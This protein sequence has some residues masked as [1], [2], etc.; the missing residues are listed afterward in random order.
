VPRFKVP[1][2]DL[3]LLSVTL[4]WGFNFAIMK[5][6][7]R[8]FHPFAFNAL[9]FT[10]TSVTMLAILKAAGKPLRVDRADLPAVAGLALVSTTAYHFLFSLGLAHTLA[11]NSAVVM[12]FSPIFAYGMGVLLQREK[13]S[14]LVAGGIA[15]SAAG[16]V[17]IAAS[18]PRGLALGGSWRG[19]LLTLGAAFCWGFY[20]GSSG[21]LLEKYGTLRLTVLVMVI[22]TV[23]LV[24]LSLPW[25]LRQ[26]WRHITLPI[27]CSI[28]YSAFLSIVYCY[29]AWFYALGRVGIARTA[30]YSNVTPVVAFVGGWLLLGERPGIGQAVGAALVLTGV[31][32]VRRRRPVEAP[33]E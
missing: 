28:L 1:S 29:F 30:V 24:P 26:D 31:F 4:V 14:A 20:T 17:A 32:L 25:V 19:D 12:A 22:G 21:R 6:L 11:G 5:G 18:S 8:Y 9:R 16:V 33:D 23:F 2:V 7:Y 15:L 27:W 13:P 3:L 10:L